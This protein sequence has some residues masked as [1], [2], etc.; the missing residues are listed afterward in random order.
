VIVAVGPPEHAVAHAVSVAVVFGAA[1]RDAVAVLVHRIRF[2]R[3]VA[4][5]GGARVNRGVE[6]VAVGVRAGTPVLAPDGCPDAGEAVTVEVL[7]HAGQV[8]AVTI[9][10]HA[11]P[12]GIE[13]PE[14]ASRVVVVAVLRTGRTILVGVAQ[15]RDTVTVVIDGVV[16]VLLRPRVDV[17]VRVVTIRRL[18]VDEEPIAICVDPGALAVGTIRAVVVESVA[19]KR[20]VARLQSR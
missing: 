10:I 19:A 2:V 8:D 14:V 9:L 18:P 7:G 5:F 17:D 6:V 15:R 11:I 13:R 16:A 4:A 1:L 20:S 12:T 3:I